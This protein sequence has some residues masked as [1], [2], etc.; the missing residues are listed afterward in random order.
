MIN[1]ANR[2]S[3]GA[4]NPG[5]RA[6]LISTG[7]ALGTAALAEALSPLIPVAN[8][9]ERRIQ[10]AVKIHEFQR[11]L[12]PNGNV[13]SERIRPAEELGNAYLIQLL[14]DRGR[15]R[16]GIQRTVAYIDRGVGR[17]RELYRVDKRDGTYESKLGRDTFVFEGFVD[18]KARVRLCPTEQ[19]PCGRVEWW[20]GAKVV[21][22]KIEPGWAIN[23]DNPV[24]IIDVAENCE[25]KDWRINSDIKPPAAT[26]TVVP[27]VTPVP[28]TV[29]PRPTPP[30]GEGAP[31]IP[32][33]PKPPAS[34][35]LGEEF[36]MVA[37]LQP[38]EM[39]R[40]VYE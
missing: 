5:K 10:V 1:P 18:T 23:Y 34:I 38:G 40:T 22:Y 12:D 3:S 21:A 35:S 19:N 25:P 9:L 33:P 4:Q 11:F 15:E 27:E 37:L 20:D 14:Q 26:S 39:I 24:F 2:E 30:P 6:F 29:T 8:A 13:A 17:G 28:A 31:Q 16:F 32:R 7:T 36:G